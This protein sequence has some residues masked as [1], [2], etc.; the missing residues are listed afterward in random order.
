MAE[1]ARPAPTGAPGSTDPAGYPSELVRD[2]EDDGLRYHVRPIR[3]DDGGRL[4][5]LH[6]RLSAHSL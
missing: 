5:D 4:V 1:T 6:G 3:P 2:V